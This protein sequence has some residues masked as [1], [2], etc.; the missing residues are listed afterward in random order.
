MNVLVACEF[1]G[2]IK[3]AFLRHNV[4]AFSCDLLPTESFLKSSHI[5]T[6]VLS[7]LNGIDDLKWDLII[8][9]PPCT[10]LSNSGAR[11]HLEK[12]IEQREAIRFF[13]SF[14]K[15]PAPYIAVENPKGVMSTFFRQPDQTIQP[16]MFGHGETKATCL[17]LKGLPLLTPTEIVSGRKAATFNAYRGGAKERWQERSRTLHGIANAMAAQWTSYIL[18][19]ERKLSE[20]SERTLSCRTLQK[21]PGS[22]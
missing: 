9:H 8:A 15:A 19:Q 14:I 4:N 6:D 13:M 22:A 7:V 11:W 2:I 18:T 16:W 12:K 17:W 20:R 10:Y 21:N 3:D 5:Q 1:S